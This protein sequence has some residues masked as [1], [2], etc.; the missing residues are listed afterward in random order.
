VLW[1]VTILA[2]GLLAYPIVRA[3]LPGLS[4]RGYPLARVVGLLLWAWFAWMGGSL[5]L[6]YSKA[7]IAAAL[8]LVAL[9]GGWQ[10]WRQR[11]ELK[12]E[13]RQRWKYF[14]MV[15]LVHQPVELFLR[16][17]VVPQGMRGDDAA[18]L[19]GVLQVVIVY[20]L[21]R[22]KRFTSYEWLA[23]SVCIL[24]SASA[25]ATPWPREVFFVA[26][27]AISSS[28]RRLSKGSEPP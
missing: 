11:A 28:R 2:L 27:I 19:I 15:E 1:Y 21:W 5:G 8:G 13:F 23:A 10:A 20:G 4:D 18:L 24:A 7:T 25:Y 9:I 22:I 6:T 14:L 17:A 16:H 3:A 12:Q 26:S